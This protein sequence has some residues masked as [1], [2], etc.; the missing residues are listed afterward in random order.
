MDALHLTLACKEKRKTLGL[1][2]IFASII[3][4]SVLVL[5]VQINRILGSTF[6][7]ENQFYSVNVGAY[8]N[9]LKLNDTDIS[10]TYKIFSL[11]EFYEGKWK[12]ETQKFVVAQQFENCLLLRT[13]GN[14]YTYDTLK[15]WA[16]WREKPYFKLELWKLYTKNAWSWN[17]QII[18]DVVNTGIYS[19]LNFSWGGQHKI[20]PEQPTWVAFQCKNGIFGFVIIETNDPELH[21]QFPPKNGTEVQ[22]NFHAAR[23]RVP[24][25]HHTGDKEFVKL[26]VYANQNGTLETFKEWVKQ[27]T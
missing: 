21:I 15:F 7:F 14:L 25:Y 3:C 6:T 20:L 4:C 27:E 16:F 26:L 8:V 19:N 5:Y 17:N 23:D 10:A 13:G 11:E 24:E 9:W 1:M 12:L 2:L 18:I 22:I